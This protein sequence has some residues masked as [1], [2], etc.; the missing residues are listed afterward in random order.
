MLS[1]TAQIPLPVCACSCKA[2]I[3]SSEKGGESTVQHLSRPRA[4]AAA[5]GRKVLPTEV[6]P[7][8][9]GLFCE[10]W[11]NTK[12]NRRGQKCSEQRF[13]RR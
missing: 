11:K 3:E 4:G 5:R 8:P 12:T 6:P 1:Q 10:S 7:E 2:M 13:K 9:E